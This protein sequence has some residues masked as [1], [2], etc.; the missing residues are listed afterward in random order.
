MKVAV[1]K[2]DLACDSISDPKKGAQALSAMLTGG[3]GQ[4]AEATA[5]IRNLYGTGHGRTRTAGADGR[6]AR[7]VVGACSTLAAFL[8]ETLDARKAS[9]P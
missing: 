4:I 9:T 5:A 7:L 3:L 8:L 6:H 1:A 2:L